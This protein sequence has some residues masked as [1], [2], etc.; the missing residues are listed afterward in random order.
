MIVRTKMLLPLAALTLAFAFAAPA[1][2]DD[3]GK[4]TG[5]DQG[6]MSQGGDSKMSAPMSKD[7]ASKTS[8]SGMGGSMS[9]SNMGDQNG[10]SGGMSK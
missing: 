8:G 7:N 5:K 1:L 10:G 9:K 6:G 3:M 2:A 4:S